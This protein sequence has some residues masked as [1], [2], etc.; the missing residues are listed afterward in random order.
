MPSGSED[1][2]L[3]RDSEQQLLLLANE[4]CEYADDAARSGE[5]DQHPDIELNRGPVVAMNPGNAT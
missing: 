3:P 2:Y 1:V 5:H 4:G